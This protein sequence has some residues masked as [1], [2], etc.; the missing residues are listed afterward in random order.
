MTKEEY[1]QIIDDLMR[2]TSKQLREI[3]R[4]EGICLGYDSARKSS[5]ARC[6]ASH[7]WYEE[8]NAR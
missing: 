7:R 8:V 3:A 1:E 4:D 6:I 5:M 2:L